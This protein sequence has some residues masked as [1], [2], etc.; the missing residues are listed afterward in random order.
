MSDKGNSSV[1]PN[2]MLAVFCA[3]SRYVQGVNA[4]SEL[5]EVLTAMGLTGPALIVASERVETA[6]GPVWASTL[7][8]AGIPYVVH[9]FHGEC[10]QTEINAGA[11]AAR[12]AGSATVIGAGGGK[13]L[14]ASRAIAA[15]CGLH[16]VNCPTLASSDA[17]CSAL[18][19]V[20]TDDGS[21][22][23][24]LFYR[25]N[26][27]LVL[28]DTSIIARAPERYLVGGMGDALATWFEARTVIEARQPNQLQG[29][30]TRTAEALAKLCY[31][32]LL[33]DG[34]AALA[35]VRAGSVT[36]ALERIVEANTLL[37]G[38]GFES[39][40]L[41]IAHSVHNGLTMAP[42]THQYLHGEKVAFGLLVQL[43][44]EGRPQSEF[45][46][47]V[48]FSREV[49]LPTSLAEVG[50]ADAGIDMLRSIAERTVAPG[51]TAHHEPF[52][53][54]ADMILDG[55]RAADSVARSIQ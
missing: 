26:P 2:R 31:E 8:R 40:G 24:Y 9:R 3:P 5:G 43:V 34:P 44:V 13:A 32:T 1:L 15:E 55:I 16:T 25:R 49:G 30:T 52:A 19:V 35:A 10:T 33:A 7:G 54:S 39:G 20:Y 46:E 22:D 50:L 29:A 27:D 18:S 47:V 23:R 17:P 42:A 36:P 53:V 14:D 6:L 11:A 51:E 4:T 37:S 38:L 28:V 21:F 48:R 12:A 41:A 45:T